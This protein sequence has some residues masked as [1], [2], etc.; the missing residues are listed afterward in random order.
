[1]LLL[2]APTSTLF[3]YTTLFRSGLIICV[4][5]GRPPRQTRRDL[6]SGGSVPAIG[7]FRLDIW[8]GG[9][10]SAARFSAQPSGFGNR[11]G[12]EPTQSDRNESRS[13][14]AGLVKAPDCPANCGWIGS[15]FAR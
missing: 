1:F 15:Q 14:R 7:Q 11:R 4:V 8:S 10:D 5:A 12:D 13:A 9:P 2:P 3:P 6:A